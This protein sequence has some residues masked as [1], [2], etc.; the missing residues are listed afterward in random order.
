[1]Q[2]KDSAASKGTTRRTAI[3]SRPTTTTALALVFLLSASV[4]LAT[5]ATFPSWFD[6]AVFADVSASV[7]SGAGFVL[8]LIPGYIDGQV[9]I[10]GP[11]YFLL[12]AELMD[13]FGLDALVFRLPSALAAY[14]S[15]LVLSVVLKRHGLGSAW[16]ILFAVVA[17]LDV[18]FNRNLVSGRMDM[19]AVLAVS[20]GVLLASMPARRSTDVFRGL[21]IG[22]LCAAA[23]LIT[24]RAL[25]LMP[26]VAVVAARD[27]WSSRR[28]NPS[29]WVIALVAPA[30]LFF[31]LPIVF[32]IA[33]VGGFP[34][35]L[36][37]F[38][39][40]EVAR[41][42][43]APSFLRSAYDNIAIIMFVGLAIFQHRH[44]F[45]SPLLIGLLLTYLA[46]SLFVSEVGPYAG[47][48][49]PFLLCALVMTLAQSNFAF[50]W[51]GF[52]IALLLV[53][54]GGLLVLRGADIMLNADCRGR[55]PVSAILASSGAGYTNVVA[56]FKY[57]FDIEEESRVLRTLEYSR[58]PEEV[59]LRDTD[60]F[61]AS[62]SDME[63][64]SSQDFQQIA[65]LSCHARRVPLLPETFYDRTTFGEVVYRRTK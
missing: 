27:L 12:Q 5:I 33:Y 24:P 29:V 8:D 34:E 48:L 44:V 11:L 64:V 22:A 32:W 20:L 9:L 4:N 31:I 50:V 13:L 40:S 62:P 6:E 36:S 18:S 15:V 42:H 30:A 63:L 35:Y 39:R 49:M 43:I 55:A 26:V 54:G 10:Y 19:L 37:Q 56:P 45:E 51:K 16:V 47:M 61:I 58:T 14:L 65:I 17:L 38:T 59:V 41:A 23:F 25:F 28:D 57:F 60:L 52:A 3:G 21:T 2:A 7:R 46:F 1:M 53:P